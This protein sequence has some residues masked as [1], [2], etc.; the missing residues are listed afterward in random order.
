MSFRFRFLDNPFIV[1]IYP[2]PLQSMSHK[3]SLRSVICRTLR[4]Q[5]G[6]THDRTIKNHH[7]IFLCR[8]SLFWKM[9]PPLQISTPLLLCVY[10]LILPDYFRYLLAWNGPPILFTQGQICIKP[11]IKLS[12][13]L[14][15]SLRNY[16]TSCICN[17]ENLIEIVY[18]R[19]LEIL[20]KKSIHDG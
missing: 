20:W 12:A 17:R 1:I 4:I 9:V 14:I 18:D 11:V 15:S 2:A 19:Q 10:A 6:C 8:T 13:C 5:V 16:L 7:N 3:Y